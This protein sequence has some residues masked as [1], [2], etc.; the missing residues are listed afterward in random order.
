MCMQDERQ[1]TLV[2]GQAKEKKM[3]LAYRSIYP[4][5][6]MC[7]MW[8]WTTRVDRSRNNN[9]N[10]DEMSGMHQTQLGNER[11]REIERLSRSFHHVHF[12][13]SVVRCLSMISE[14]Y[15]IWMS[16]T[17]RN[18]S[19]R[20]SNSKSLSLLFLTLC[21]YS[22]IHFQCNG[23]EWVGRRARPRIVHVFVRM[24]FF[25]SLSQFSTQNKRKKNEATFLFFFL[26]VFFCFYL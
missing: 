21:D 13:I 5:E 4:C 20:S 23:N 26:L 12:D 6:F 24:F 9:D 1:L 2:R 25:L 14:L 15:C 11:R 7:M 10:V 19:R 22:S 18:T 3:I 8:C 16:G 17:M